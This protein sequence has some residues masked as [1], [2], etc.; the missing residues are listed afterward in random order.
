MDKIKKCDYLIIRTNEPTVGFIERFGYGLSTDGIEPEEYI[1][2]VQ[3]VI[4]SENYL[5]YIASVGYRCIID[6]S[7]IIG[8]ASVDQLTDEDKKEPKPLFPFLSEPQYVYTN[9]EEV[10]GSSIVEKCDYLTR[11]AMSSLFPDSKIVSCLFSESDYIKADLLASVDSSINH[12][13]FEDKQFL[14]SLKKKRNYFEEML[15][16]LRFK[17]YYEV[18][19]GIQDEDDENTTNYLMVVIDMALEKV[20]ITTDIDERTRFFYSLGPEYDSIY[21]FYRD[22]MM[23]TVTKEK[24]IEMEL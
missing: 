24:I 23:E 15:Q 19:V 12:G 20:V 11:K 18:T 6:S 2:R 9:N 14:E 10:P 13:K 1:A 17:E 22:L 16:H 21:R 7:E 3:E 4:D 8:F 5:V